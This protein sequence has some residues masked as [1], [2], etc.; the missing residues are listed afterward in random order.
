VEIFYTYFVTPFLNIAILI[1]ST[2]GFSNLGITVIIMTIIMRLFLL[3]V[4]ISSSKIELKLKELESEIL[5]IEGSTTNP[6][7]RKEKLNHL[8]KSNKIDPYKD[9]LSLGVQVFFGFLL[10]FSFKLIYNDDYKNN[11]YDFLEGLIPDTVDTSFLGIDLSRPDFNLSVIASALLFLFLFFQSGKI[12]EKGTSTFSY[13]YY[14][15]LMPI[16]VFG[17]LSILSATKAIFLMVSA[18][19]SVIIRFWVNF[20][21]RKSIRESLQNVSD[22]PKK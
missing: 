6:Q 21:S 18:L 11:I 19:F 14:N 12:V 2:I 20:T 7:T 4:S 16:L 5:K 8:F 15:L 3:P 10:Y 9:T 13:K 17:I 22:Y 1:Y